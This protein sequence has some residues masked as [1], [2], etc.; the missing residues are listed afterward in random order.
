MLDGCEAIDGLIL[1]LRQLV[2]MWLSEHGGRVG[3][4][5]YPLR[6]HA[7]ASAPNSALPGLRQAEPILRPLVPSTRLVLTCPE[8]HIPTH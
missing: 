6:M 8:S 7:V 4:A 5:H 3:F 1:M 2:G